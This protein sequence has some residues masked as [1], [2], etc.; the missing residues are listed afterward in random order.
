MQIRTTDANGVEFSSDAPYLDD[1]AIATLNTFE[2]SK[3]KI[4]DR[5]RQSGHFLGCQVHAQ[6][7]YEQNHRG[8]R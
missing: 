7:V 5:N 2:L 6:F 4:K 3:K 8:S 1:S